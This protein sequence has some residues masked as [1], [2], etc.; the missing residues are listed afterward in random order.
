VGNTTE[1]TQLDRVERKLDEIL[2]MR[3]LALKFFLPR[4]PAA[5]RPAAMEL[6]A[7]REG[8]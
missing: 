1:E 8:R 5:L 4:I 6:L 7:K 2:M 3:D